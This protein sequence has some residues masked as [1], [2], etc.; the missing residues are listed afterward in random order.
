M[1]YVRKV[2]TFLCSMQMTCVLSGSFEEVHMLSIWNGEFW[3]DFNKDS[4]LREK[5]Q[6]E[7]FHINVRME[8][9]NEQLN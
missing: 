8:V 9:E 5:I 2:D 6:M 4:I 3:F 1:K 7:R